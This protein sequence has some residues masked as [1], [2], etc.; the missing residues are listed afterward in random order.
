MGCLSCKPSTGAVTS[1]GAVTSSSTVVTPPPCTSDYGAALKPGSLDAAPLLGGTRGPCSVAS[2]AATRADP[3][4]PP[5]PPP[6]QLPRAGVVANGGPRSVGG[7]GRWEALHGEHKVPSREDVSADDF[8]LE[9]V[10]A[11]IEEC[12]TRLEEDS[13]LVLRY[14]TPHFTARARVRVPP[15]PRAAEQWHVGWIQACTRMT[16]HN[17]YGDLGLSSWELPPLRDGR[18]RTVS[19]ADGSLYPWYGSSGEVLTVTGPTLT[20][21]TFSLGM[22]DNFYPSVTWAVPVS[23]A[24][25]A[26]TTGSAH[27]EASSREQQQGPP[28]ETPVTAPPRCGSRPPTTTTT[29]TAT[30]DS[31]DPGGVASSQKTPRTP[32]SRDRG[33]ARPDGAT[34]E[35]P[36]GRSGADDKTTMTAAPSSPSSPCLLSPGQP[37]LTVVLRDQ[38]FVSWLAA[39]CG[40]GGGGG[41]AARPV[42]LATVSWR[43]RLRVAV[44]PGAPLGQR[45]RL[46]GPALQEPPRVCRYGAKGRGEDR[47]GEGGDGGGGGP[48]VGNGLNGLEEALRGLAGVGEGRERWTRDG[49][50]PCRCG[51]APWLHAVP[52]EVLGPPNANGAQVLMWRPSVGEPLLVI[53]AKLQM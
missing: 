16:F 14:V 18:V 23:L 10:H 29:D 42:V 48:S 31:A 27:R 36:P 12:P 11:S 26:A 4:G 24:A 41:D 22:S 47:C 51:L 30:T 34:R 35:S 33:S 37:A 7:L 32:P 44:E 49:G 2:I 43:M 15:V 5:G 1:N 3:G 6:L 46:L 40:G 13:A 50:A 45:A 25:T 19:D 39:R 17:I 28:R 8:V 38:S 9:E 53:P 21:T 52:D 20:P